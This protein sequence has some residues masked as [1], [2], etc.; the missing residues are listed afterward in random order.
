[1]KLLVGSLAKDGEL[2][3][4]IDDK[5]VWSMKMNCP[6]Y[7]Y[8]HNKIYYT[9]SQGDSTTLYSFKIVDDKPEIIST[10]ILDEKTISHLSMYDNELIC[11]SV[12]SGYFHIVIVENG[13]FIKLKEK[14]LLGGYL[15]SKCHQATFTKDGKNLIFVNIKQNRLYFYDYKNKCLENE[16][17]MEFEPETLPRH[18]KFSNDEKVFY[19]ITEKSNEIIT[20]ETKSHKILQRLKLAF[21]PVSNSKG[22]TIQINKNGTILY[23]NLRID[24][25]IQAYYINDDYTLTLKSCFSS[26]GNNARHMILSNDEKYLISANINSNNVTIISTDKK[27]LIKQIPFE[28]AASVL[29]V[30]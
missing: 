6:K 21:N 5:K 14:R 26:F 16:T 1:M 9:Y 23:T 27:E 18:I 2:A 8:E 17:I 29:E 28:E 3:Y 4:F 15:P 13:K 20:I 7:I 24:D 10:F 12:D 19:L 11:S 25:T 22:C 30:I